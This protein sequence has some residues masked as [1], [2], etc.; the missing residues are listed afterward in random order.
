LYLKRIA[1][2]L[3][4]RIGME[5]MKKPKREVLEM[6][7]A[8][9]DGMS[10][11]RFITA[12]ARGFDI[13]R[14]FQPGGGALGNQELSRATGIPKATVTRL[15]HTLAEL[16]Y[17]RHLKSEG[18]YEPTEAILALGYSVLSNLLVRQ[19]AHDPMMELA[20][21]HDVSVGLASRDR[22]SMIFVD[23]CKNRMLSTLHLEVGS[24]VPMPTT[25]VGRAFLAGV[26]EA[27]RAF[28]YERFE[29]RLGADEW[30]ALRPRVENA[31]AQVE[32]RG[33][34]YVEDEWHRGMRAVATPLVAR[35]RNTVMSMMCGAPAFRVEREKLET[36][37]GPRL[38]HLCEGLALSVR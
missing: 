4:G 29:E 36:E 27:E 22:L 7:D 38:V 15:T 11:R 30:P 6:E 21:Q 3:Q 18:K 17:L 14:A 28:Y 8:L 1:T 31:I 10:D 26:P 13:L 32:D 23:V 2:T 24:R 20:L 9:S 5:R 35:D 34:C 37:L 25:A 12:L 16:G 33:F 19:V